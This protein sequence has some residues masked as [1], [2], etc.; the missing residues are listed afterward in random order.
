MTSVEFGKF[1]D[2]Q[3]RAFNSSF[4]AAFAAQEAQQ[5]KLLNPPAPSKPINTP[6]PSMQNSFRSAPVVPSSSVPVV[7]HTSRPVA[8]AVIPAP[9]DV[10]TMADIPD[11]V[12]EDMDFEKLLE[13]AEANFAVPG[14]SAVKMSH[15]TSSAVSTSTVANYNSHTLATPRAT[16]PYTSPPSTS[17]PPPRNMP[18]TVVPAKVSKL[19]HCNVE[20]DVVTISTSM[21]RKKSLVCRQLMC[22][23]VEWV[24]DH[25]E[26]TIVAAGSSYSTPY[27]HQSTSNFGGDQAY[28]GGKSMVYQ[29][30]A[31]CCAGVTVVFSPLISLI[32]DQ[33]DAL[34]AMGIRA[35]CLSQSSVG[36]DYESSE[37]RM[38]LQELRSYHNYSSTPI[39][40]LPPAEQTRIQKEDEQR[41]KML[42]VTPEKF[43]RSQAV[44]SLLQQLMHHQL[45]SR[46]VLDEA[47]CL[48]QWGHDFRPDYLRL[49][50]IRSLCP[51]VPIMALTATA[52][53]SVVQDIIKILQMK[54]PFVH[55]MSFNRPNLQYKV[56]QKKSEKHTLD[57]IAN[58][59]VSHMQ[60][61]GIIYCLSRKDCETLVDDMVALKPALRGKISFYHAD[62]PVQEKEY[63]Q[64]QWFKGDI[65]VLC[66]TIAFGMGI[67]KPDV[68]YVIHLHMPKSLTNYYQESGRAGRDGLTAECILYYS[69]K[70][71]S[72]VLSMLDKS[73]GSYDG[74]QRQL[75]SLMKCLDFCLDEVTCR[76][77]L[78]LSYFGETFDATKCKNTC[79]TCQA[80]SVLR[81]SFSINGIPLS[82]LIETHDITHIATLAVHLVMVTTGDGPGG[83]GG[84]GGGG[85]SGYRGGRGGGNQRYQ[86]NRLPKLTAS[87]L[88]K[89]L[90][91]SKGKEVNQ[92]L[93]SLNGL[94]ENLQPLFRE[95]DVYNIHTQYSK[96]AME[97][98][99]HRIIID[100]F[101]REEHVVTNMQGNYGADYLVLGP[102]A[103]EILDQKQRVYVKF[104]GSLPTNGYGPNTGI[105]SSV[106]A[107][108]SKKNSSKSSHS[109]IV[110]TNGQLGHGYA[111]QHNIEDLLS[112]GPEG[113]D[114]E[115]DPFA[116]EE[117][118]VHGS[119]VRPAM[120]TTAPAAPSRRGAA[121]ASAAA[122]VIVADDTATAAVA[123]NAS[124][125]RKTT[126]TQPS[127]KQKDPYAYLDASDGDDDV[128]G[129]FTSTRQPTMAKVTTRS[130]PLPAAAPKH[131]RVNARDA[132]SDSHNDSDNIDD[133]GEWGDSEDSA[134][135]RARPPL[136]KP[137][138]MQP[139]SVVDLLEDS[140]AEEV[141]LDPHE[142][143]QRV[144]RRRAAQKEFKAAQRQQRRKSREHA[145]PAAA[146]TQSRQNLSSLSLP[147]H[148]TKRALNFDK[149]GD[150]GRAEGDEDED[151]DADFEQP[152]RRTSTSRKSLLSASGS[153]AGGKKGFKPPYASQYSKSEQRQHEAEEA[154]ALEAQRLDAMGDNGLTGRQQDALRVWLQAY[155]RRWANYWHHL[156]DA[157]L[158]Y[159]VTV[160]IP[161]TMDEIAEVPGIGESRA[162]RD[163]PELLA[164]LDTGE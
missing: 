19:C 81:Q 61:T 151:D 38:L 50:D 156:S 103:R 64:R 69:Y 25:Q 93:S 33:V 67:N 94:K 140:D 13:Q 145:R 36:Q 55:T 37:G 20:C 4:K 11:S 133:D 154:A 162:M 63:R 30:P 34:N 10:D 97:V 27:Q 161:Q 77:Q 75:V 76:R 132:S 129:A 49:A 155:R 68:R 120:T 18:S 60:W 85:N 144:A 118:R 2:G 14:N 107:K 117:E 35:V 115:E 79:D 111:Q 1:V 9:V 3:P 41:I 16:L 56:L 101:I 131:R 51:T 89:L 98:I 157:S 143:A 130:A 29:L 78:I 32:Q 163:G 142:V 141:A 39:D 125:K 23:F 138:T 104:R 126:P 87:K 114:D 70:D 121:A 146:A 95:Q 15:Q 149:V 119:E 47:H 59:I 40:Q 160:S 128:D 136:K 137:R 123:N 92:Y 110:Q 65:R 17:M 88:A 91:G 153:K 66:A 106:A 113:D 72:R 122:A 74:Q 12:L 53:Q 127:K 158:E 99:C 28:G 21:A 26:T 31:W 46:F 96:E 52:N 147:G 5:A 90:S 48:S 71:K 135:Q 6:A 124:R 45:L 42:Y 84:G 54:A 152:S 80:M 139:D 116:Q 83:G 105:T 102:R 134:M 7:N 44:R 108:N 8:P 43:S 109:N 73:Q 159:I 100:G 112:D 24:N 22:T 86:S 62:L 148:S 58:Y 164:T 57:E 82:R 150:D